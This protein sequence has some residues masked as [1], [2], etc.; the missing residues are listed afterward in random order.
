M[1]KNNYLKEQ[2]LYCQYCNKE[3]KNL[4]SL[5]QHECRCKQNP[6]RIITDEYRKKLGVAVRRSLSLSNKIPPNTL[7]AEKRIIE[8][9]KNPKLCLQCGKPLTYQQAKEGR[10]FCCHKC[11]NQNKETR[12]PRS[13][14]SRKKTRESM[15]NNL[16]KGN[17]KVWSYNKRFKQGW[18]KGFHCDSSYELVYLIYCLDHNINI[19]KCDKKYE[20]FYKGL[21]HLYFPDFI[22]NNDTIVEIKGYHNELVD[23]KTNSVNDMNYKILYKEDLQKEF[24]YVYQTYNVNDKTIQ[25]LYEKNII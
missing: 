10:K 9:N 11:S 12:P 1:L 25:T 19:K 2:I 24:E 21:K 17:T 18:Y 20:Y 6:N 23:I 14:E 22:I 4:N 7:K 3:C 16:I 5:K 13:E 8:Y 15:F